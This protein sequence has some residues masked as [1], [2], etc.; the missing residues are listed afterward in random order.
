MRRATSS[1]GSVGRGGWLMLEIDLLP[2]AVFD[3][4]NRQPGGSANGFIAE[5]RVK[6]TLPQI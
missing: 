1:L 5:S 2:V 6:A 4:Q 3:G